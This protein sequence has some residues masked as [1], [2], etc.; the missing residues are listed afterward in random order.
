[1]QCLDGGNASV[2]KLAEEYE[3]RETCTNT[4]QVGAMSK[5]VIEIIDLFSLFSLLWR[6]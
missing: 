3:T 4:Q 5:I 6:I 1:M 2:S